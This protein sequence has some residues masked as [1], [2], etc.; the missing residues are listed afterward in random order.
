MIIIEKKTIEGL[1]AEIQ[2]IKI[3]ANKLKDQFNIQVRENKFLN[4]MV[5]YINIRQVFKFLIT[6]LGIYH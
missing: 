5:K 4:E 3:S 2:R 6:M 1:N